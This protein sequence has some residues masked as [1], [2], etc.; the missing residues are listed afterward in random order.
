MPKSFTHFCRAQL[1]A[2][3][4][5]KHPLFWLLLPILFVISWVISLIAKRRR[6]PSY[7]AQPTIPFVLCVGNVS[8]G[9]SGKSPVVQKLA[10]DYL[11]SGH[12][13]GIA[14]RGITQK[15]QPVALCSFDTKNS[16]FKQRLS[17]L[18]DENREHYE[19]LKEISSLPFFIFQNRNRAQAL[20]EFTKLLS[21]QAT[22]LPLKRAVLILDDGLQHFQCP[23]DVNIG[24]WQP[25]LLNTSP[26]FSMPVG[27]YRE[28]FGQA[29]MGKLLSEFDYRLW[30]RTTPEL[31]PFLITEARHALRKYQIR[32]VS[33]K[34]IFTTYQLKIKRWIS[35][36]WIDHESPIQE[37]D[38]GV[39]TGIA[40]PEFFLN[41][42]K[43]ITLERVN[44]D[45]L[46]LADH[47]PFN[48][49]LSHFINKHTTLVFTL[50]D[51]CRWFVHPEFQAQ[52]RNKI[53][54]CCF[55][56]VSFW[57]HHQTPLDFAEAI[58]KCS[59]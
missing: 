59:D 35:K 52:I 43:S 49:I 2:A 13:V 47:A 3:W 54:Y 48:K 5:Q 44:F 55:V 8:L 1:D 50:K 17:Q 40:Y 9:G 37:T 24:L 10:R 29:S 31:L 39:A 38:I 46:F 32:D 25:R 21:K 53:V 27:P 30:S 41:D 20:Q 28:G 36:E 19:R 18:S 56:D 33:N 14:A 15:N 58:L 57:S 11:L 45:T 16:D 22:P 6:T 4:N 7:T 26:P 42:L 51:F 12:I 34:D 23:R